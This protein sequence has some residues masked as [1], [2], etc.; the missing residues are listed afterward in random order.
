MH[1]WI[2]FKKD[3]NNRWNLLQNR[4]VRCPARGT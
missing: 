1:L 3:G 4:V 2:L